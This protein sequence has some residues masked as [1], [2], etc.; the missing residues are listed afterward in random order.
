MHD[1]SLI[2]HNNE[3]AGC[4]KRADHCMYVRTWTL[5]AFEYGEI[6]LFLSQK[7]THRILRVCVIYYN[8]KFHMYSHKD[9]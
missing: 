1:E 7:N 5:V 4:L 9:V 8:A 6:N 2:Q 3:N